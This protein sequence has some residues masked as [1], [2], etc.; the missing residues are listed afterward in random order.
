M[1]DKTDPAMSDIRYMVRS[2]VLLTPADGTYLVCALPQNA[3]VHNVYVNKTTAYADGSALLEVGFTGNGETDD[4][5]AFMISSDVNPANT[6]L[7]SMAGG[8]AEN[9]AGKWFGDAGG[10]VTVTVDDVGDTAG[11]FQ[12]FVDYSILF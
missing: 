11:T 9:E 7:V 12:V 6:G 2:K 1:F 8:N 10:G 4:T 3:F 5:N